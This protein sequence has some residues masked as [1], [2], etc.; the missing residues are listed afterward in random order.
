MEETQKNFPKLVKYFEKF[1]GVGDSDVKRQNL[2]LDKLEKFINLQKT[3]LEKANEEM[4]NKIYPDASLFNGKKRM[5]LYILIEYSKEINQKFHEIVDEYY[6]D[7]LFILNQVALAISDNPKLIINVDKFTNYMIS[8]IK[9]DDT[10]IKYKH[11]KQ[12]IDHKMKR[13]ETKV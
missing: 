9:N 8:K 5:I 3:K 12:L 11:M 13:I 1:G 10:Y 6:S 2:Q 7:L 4:K